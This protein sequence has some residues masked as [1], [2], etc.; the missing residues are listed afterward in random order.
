MS[1]VGGTM[2]GRDTRLATSVYP[3]M[4]AARDTNQR[5]KRRVTTPVPGYGDT[6]R[7]SV[8][9]TMEVGMSCVWCPHNPQPPLSPDRVHYFLGV[10]H[11]ARISMIDDLAAV[12]GVEPVGDPA[13]IRQVRFG[14]EERDLHL[15]DLPYRVDEP[16]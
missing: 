13:G 14:D 8:V 12:D 7:N 2:S 3:A 4:S 10:E 11:L 15:L 1:C 6:I 5:R 9:R 16:G